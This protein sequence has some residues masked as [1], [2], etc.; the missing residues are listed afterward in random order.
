MKNNGVAHLNSHQDCYPSQLRTT[1]STIRH[2][3]LTEIDENNK[4]VPSR[5]RKSSHGRKPS[6]YIP[7][8]MQEEDLPS[9]IASHSKVLE[10]HRH[11]KYNVVQ[12]HI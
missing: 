12:D 5:R 10:K 1:E 6:V 3:P 8:D 2:S 4:P 11:A 7:L 9:Q